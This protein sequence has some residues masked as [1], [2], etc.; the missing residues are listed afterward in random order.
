MAIQKEPV[1]KIVKEFLGVPL[2][3]ELECSVAFYRTVFNHE[4]LG[5]QNFRVGAPGDRQVGLVFWT[6][7][8]PVNKGPSAGESACCH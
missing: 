6:F 3:S 4:V 2:C 8:E 5:I 7:A 1:W